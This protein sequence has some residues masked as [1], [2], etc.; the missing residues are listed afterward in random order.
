MTKHVDTPCAITVASAA[1]FTPMLSP[2][3][4]T[5][6]STIFVIA[7]TATLHILT[8]VFPCA[9]IKAFNPKVSCV[10]NVPKQ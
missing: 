6:S 5:A 9:V 10:N 1:P 2:L 8:N 3:I 4:S 7:P